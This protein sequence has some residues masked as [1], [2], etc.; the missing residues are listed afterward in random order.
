MPIISF[1]HGSAST[2]PNK[3]VYVIYL[4]TFSLFH[5]SKNG[6]I[7]DEYCGGKDLEGKIAVSVNP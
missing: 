5:V 6:R 7:T 3:Q 2:L 4:T 1:V